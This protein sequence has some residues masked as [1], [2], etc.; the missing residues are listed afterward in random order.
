M[1]KVWLITGSSRG[2]GRT[3]A[4]LALAAG[5]Q[6]LASTR[7]PE[8]LQEVVDR[9]GDQIRTVQG[10]VTR[11]S[12]ARKAVQ[13]ALDAFDRI[14]VVVNAARSA[15]PTV[16]DF[17]V[18][19]FR[20]PMDTNLF[21][22]AYLIEAVWP[23]LRQQGS[24]HIIEIPPAGSRI[25]TLGLSPY[26]MSKDAVENFTVEVAREVAPY[27]IKVTIVE[28]GACNPRHNRSESFVPV[29]GQRDSESTANP[30]ERAHAHDGHEP[31]ETG[32]VA[33]LILSIAGTA[34]PPLR[35]LGGSEVC[36]HVADAG[37]ALAAL[38]T[39]WRN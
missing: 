13:T 21:G 26:H 16:E 20:V 9:Y 36:Q 18:E 7:T 4:E 31:N 15:E 32:S 17:S 2:L 38:K 24:E 34:E 11:P 22:F 23:V 27:G 39:K 29:V 37:Q 19:T 8:R 35:L 33:R 28:T 14:D 12:A 30:P 6:V 1:S 10:D 25:P 5:D 3:I